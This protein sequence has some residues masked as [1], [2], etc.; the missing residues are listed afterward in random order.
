MEK[1]LDNKKD[2]NITDELVKSA[3][4][5]TNDFKFSKTP[6]EI[7]NDKPKEVKK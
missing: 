6:S 3:L 5:N 7:N 2:D 4:D 1:K